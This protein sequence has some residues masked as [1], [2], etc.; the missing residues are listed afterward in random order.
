MDGTGMYVQWV[1]LWP[2]PGGAGSPVSAD[3]R[4]VTYSSQ[5]ARHLSREGA[6]LDF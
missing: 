3:G 4:R 5:E 6:T 1:K 2:L